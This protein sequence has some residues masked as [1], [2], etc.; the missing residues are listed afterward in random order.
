LEKKRQDKTI[1]KALEA[2][3]EIV[4]PQVQAKYSDPEMLREL[5]NV[6]ALKMTIGEPDSISV[7]KADGQKCGRCWH[8]E[9]DVGSNPA[10]PA[11]CGRCAEAVRR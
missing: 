2:K 6:S 8:W 3:V 9:T 10:H 7:L 4:I 1:G 11:L 5:L